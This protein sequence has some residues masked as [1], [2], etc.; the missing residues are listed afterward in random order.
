MQYLLDTCTCIDAMRGHGN[1]VKEMLGTSPGD[2]VISTITAYELFT[3]AAKCVVPDK[4]HA[5]IVLLLKSLTEL[6]F[7]SS[8]AREAGR[9]RALLEA[10]GQMIGPYDI[11][12]AAQGLAVDL[13]LVTANIA[14]FSRVPGLRTENWRLNP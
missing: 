13:T 7:D 8:A 4:E 12:L 14:E 6:S 1:V 2:C 10:R 3:G 9:I 5:K 11:L